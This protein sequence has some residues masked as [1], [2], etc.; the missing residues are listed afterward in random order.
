MLAPDDANPGLYK[1]TRLSDG[2][3]RAAVANGDTIDGFKIN[4]N[5]DLAA[6]DRLL[7][8][9]VSSATGSLQLA[10]GQ[11]RGLAAASP[12]TAV[13]VNTNTGTAAVRSVSIT[14]P[15]TAPYQPLTLRFTSATG[16]YDLL[17][18]ASAVV[19]SGTWTAGAPITYDGVA[20]MLNG[21]PASGDQ[22][23]LAPTLF[24]AAN[25]GNALAMDAM[26][27]R[28]LILGQTVTD[29]YAQV[30]TEVGVRVQGAASAADT[31]TAVAAR[32]NATLTSK[33][34]VNVDEEAAKL[35]QFQQAYQAAAKMLQTAQTVMDALLQLGR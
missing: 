12:M 11:A 1:V 23:A 19:A 22:F 16:D 3:Q 35:I 32:A 33:T 24:A 4:I 7:L 17:D 25:N 26:A 15:P 10:I 13:A 14:A 28:A 27:S 29:T 5:V 18:A 31:S 6:G 30:L 8:K 2:Q 34:G 20:L 9:P 21:V